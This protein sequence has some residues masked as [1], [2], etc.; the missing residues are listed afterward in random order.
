MPRRGLSEGRSPGGAIPR[1]CSSF[2]RIRVLALIALLASAV[3]AVAASARSAST[4][5]VLATRTSGAEPTESSNWAGYAVMIA[6]SDSS[7]AGSFTDVAGG[8]AQTKVVCRPGEPSASAFWVG[9]GGFDADAQALEQVGTEAICDQTGKPTYFAWYEFVPEGPVRVRL[10]V[11]PGDRF[12]GAVL[13]RGSDV[14]VSLKNLTRHTRFSKTFP[15]VQ[16]LDTGSAEWI[17]EAPSYCG[18]TGAC[19]VVPLANFGRVTFKGAS[20]IG[21]GKPG[22][23]NDGGW[24]ATPVLLRAATS[25]PRFGFA[26]NTHEASPSSLAP[27]G[28]SFSVSWQ[29]GAAR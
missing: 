29:E 6:A 21:N 27:D 26:A 13:V 11:R 3:L 28:R 24:D 4:G 14:V 23:I 17:A 20:A 1:T 18:P 15:S 5:L 10:S 9:L 19:G 7:T 12:S 25:N 8:W 22:T 2:L 16:P